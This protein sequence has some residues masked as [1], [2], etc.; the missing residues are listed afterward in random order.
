MKT[1][2]IDVTTIWHALNK[3]ERVFLGANRIWGTKNQQQVV[4]F[5]LYRRY[6]E[7]LNRLNYLKAEASTDWRELNHFLTENGFNEMF[8]G[9]LGGIGAVSILDMLVEWLEKANHCEIYGYDGQTHVGFEI[10][11]IGRDV[12]KVEGLN[13][14]LA[15]IK[16]KSGDSL[17]L[18]MPTK[19]PNG[20][21][22]MIGV[23][24]T[25]MAANLEPAKNITTVKLPEVDFDIKPDISF[26]CG[27]DTH[28]TSGQYW[29]IDQAYQQ[30]K[31]RINRDG[32]HVKVATGISMRKGI[33]MGPSPLI[34]N[35]PFIG[36]F[37]QKDTNLPIAIFYADYDCWKAVE[38]L[39][40]M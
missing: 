15:R 1:Q 8:T 31:L 23:A 35:K 4:V 14:P 32:A 26:L 11:E 30:F 13:S 21:L 24:F 27:A 20:P 5:E 19:E 25:T 40:S 10:P 12:Y 18:T 17:W 2:A 16:T 37:T 28:D 7:V 38:D 22:D 33:S 34:F 3:L 6:K 29:Y 36:W 9:P 39:R